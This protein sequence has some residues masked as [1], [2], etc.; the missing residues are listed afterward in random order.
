MTKQPT[1]SDKYIV[2][3]V[4]R[5]LQVLLCFARQ[6]PTPTIDEIVDAVGLHKSTAYRILSTLQHNGFV[7][8]LPQSE[9]YRLGRSIVLLG[10]TALGQM[11]LV[12]QARPHLE[13]LMQSVGETVHLAILNQNQ[14]M[15]IDKIDSQRSV[16]MA[17]TIGFRS[18]LHCTAVGKV[19]LANL[20]A[21]E[22]AELLPQLILSRYTEKT[23]TELPALRKELS[24]VRGQGFACDYEEIE[25]GLRCVAAPIHDHTGDVIAGISIA[26]PV[27]RLTLDE[28][29]KKRETVLEHATRI[30]AALGYQETR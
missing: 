14:G 20:P 9:S 18:P 29:A 28:L 11:D 17:S 24:R 2:R 23:I 12:R 1:D 4:D 15:V 13:A 10:A 6:S 7:E 3:S 30:S 21:D 22:I 25:A 16:R 27:G 19:L 8:R 26:G 5:A